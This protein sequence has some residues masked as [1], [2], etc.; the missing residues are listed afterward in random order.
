MALDLHPDRTGGDAAKTEKFRLL[1]QVREAFE[2]IEMQPCEPVV[3]KP[4]QPQVP[5]NMAYQVPPW[6]YA[7]RRAG[8]Q[9]EAPAGRPQPTNGASARAWRV[10]RIKP[11]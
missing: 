10:A 1:V 6:V 9:P 3:V 11:C 5:I 2:K 7:R 8:A 4:S